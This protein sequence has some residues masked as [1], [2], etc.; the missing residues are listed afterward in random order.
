MAH[1]DESVFALNEP[2]LRHCP[3]VTMFGYRRLREA[4]WLGQHL[5]AGIEICLLSK[6]RFD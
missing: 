4:M 1:D 3:H 6:G 5:N 2:E